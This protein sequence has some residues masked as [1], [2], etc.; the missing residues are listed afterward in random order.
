[1]DLYPTREQI[2]NV[3][4]EGYICELIRLRSLKKL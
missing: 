4:K 2:L 1:M 3:K